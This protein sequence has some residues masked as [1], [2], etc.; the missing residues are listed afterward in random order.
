MPFSLPGSILGKPTNVNKSELTPV[1][2]IFWYLDT[3]ITDIKDK[4]EKIVFDVG[5]YRGIFTKKLIKYGRQL[6]KK[7]NFFR[8]DDEHGP[9][10]FWDMFRV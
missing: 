5:C 2:P 10:L 4:K 1:K 9:K 7:F 8:I 6:G 3:K